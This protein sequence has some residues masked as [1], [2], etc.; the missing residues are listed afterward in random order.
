MSTQQDIYAAG[1]K[2]RPP[3]LN[4]DNYVPWSSRLLRY[5]KNKSNG[6]LIYDSITKG[7]YMEAN[8]KAIQTIL[9]GLPEFLMAHSQ[10]SYNYPVIHSDQPSPSSYMQQPLPNNDYNPQPSFNQNYVQQT[11]INLD[12]ISDPTIAMNM[13]LALMAKAFKLS[14]PTNN[15]KRISSNPRNRQIAQPGMNMGQDRHIQ[16][17][18]GNGGN[19]FGQ[20][21]VQNVGNQVVQNPGVQNVGNQ[22]GLIVFLR[23]PHPNG[24]QNGTGNVI[25]ARAEG[26]GYGYNDNQIRCYNCRGLG[27]YARN[28]TVRPRRRDA[29]YLQTQLLIAQKEEAKIQ[30]QAEEY[31]LM[32]VAADIDEIEEVNAN[33]ILMANLQQASTSGIQ[34]DKAPIYDSDGSAEVHCDNGY[35][36]DDICNMFTQEDQYYE[37]REPIP[38]SHLVQQNDSDVITA[39]PSVEQ[40][41]GIVEQHSATVEEIHAY[42]QSLY[43]NLAIEVKKVN[44]V[45]RNMKVT[46]AELTTELA[47]CSAKQTT[48]LNEEITNLN[49]QLS[50]EK[51]TIS[52]L[53]EER[54][55]LKSYFKKHEDELLDKQILLEDKIMGLEI[56]RNRLGHNLFSVGQFC[57]SD[58]EVAFK[59]NTCF[60]RNLKG[61]YLLKGNQTS[62]LYTINLID[63]AFASRS[64]L[65]ARAT[66]TKSSSG[67]D[68]TYAPSTITTQK[69]TEPELDLLFEAMYDDNIVLTRNQLKTDGDM[70][71]DALSVSTME[72]SNVK[73]AMTDSVAYMDSLDEFA[74]KYKYTGINDSST[75][76]DEVKKYLNSMKIFHNDG[77]GERVMNQVKAN[78]RKEQKIGGFDSEMEHHHVI[79]IMTLLQ[80]DDMEELEVANMVGLQ[81]VGELEDEFV[82]KFCMTILKLQEMVNDYDQN[83]KKKKKKQQPIRSL[84]KKDSKIFPNESV[85][86]T[87]SLFSYDVLLQI[88]QQCQTTHLESK[89]NIYFFV[90]RIQAFSRYGYDYL[91]EIV[92]CRDDYQEYTIV[93]KDFKNLYPSDFEDLNILLL[94]GRLDHL[95]GS[96]KRMLSTA[97]NINNEPKIMKFNEIYKFSDG[98]LTKILEALG[99]SVKEYKVDVPGLDVIR[100]MVTVDPYFS[101]VLQGV[102][103]GEK[104]DFVLNDG[105]LF[106]GN[107]L[108]IPDSSL[109]LQIIKELH[110]E[111]HPWVDISMDFVLGLP[112][113]Q[114][115]NDLIFVVVDR[116]SKMVH[117]IPCKKTT[118]VV[119]VAQLFFRDVY[120]LHDLPSSVVSDRDTRSVPKKVQDFVKGLHDVYKVVRDNL[121]RANSKYK[122]DADQKRRHVDFEVEVVEKMNSNAYHLKLPSHIRCSDVFNVKHLLPYHGDSSNEDSVGNSRTNFVYPGGNDVNPSIEERADLFPEAQ[123]RVRKRVTRYPT[124]PFYHL[125]YFDISSDEDSVG[126]SRTN[127]VYPGGNDVNPSS[128]RLTDMFPDARGSCEEKSGFTKKWAITLG[129]REELEVPVNQSNHR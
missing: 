104:T 41:G 117:F 39:A 12:N 36:N 126:N 50:N 33:C 107:Q 115:G 102:Q 5:A 46:N 71:I 84:S 34:T 101:V 62:N 116:F 60:V 52:F 113:T 79:N 64:F 108:C 76:Y 24:N 25:A 114:R 86:W 47:R 42:Y 7:P 56:I 123:D 66:S 70:C 124:H 54:K 122:Q 48:T 97:V 43:K 105:F 61:V 111:G 40:S 27:H 18:R 13:A 118:D 127:F 21:I 63:M 87:L 75:V 73:E 74:K 35:N 6:K 32:S 4:K 110:G 11:M 29:A 77:I 16:N 37:L 85:H 9:L 8:D 99:Y 45:N 128:G 129:S 51:S 95:S 69:P 58:L 65:M 100:D 38:E 1:S 82:K 72:P 125:H 44:M 2:N 19:Q 49:T 94:Q 93:E 90:V 109:R 96:D 59:R 67:L 30:L 81:T 22:N 23:I 20:Y 120:R 10:N 68:L 88:V 83:K 57:D 92:L 3:M 80:D 78:N 53:Q 103:S 89:T 17:V 119:N 28:C 121:V 55:K 91:K 31:D 26:T 112:R 106:K 15:N 98:T 14:T